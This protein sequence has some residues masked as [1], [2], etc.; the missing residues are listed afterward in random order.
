MVNLKNVEK[1]YDFYE[2]KSDIE[3]YGIPVFEYRNNNIGF[4]VRPT[5]VNYKESVISF[6][7]VRNGKKDNDIYQYEC[8]EISKDL[9]LV[10]VEENQY[11]PHLECV[12]TICLYDE[13][14]SFIGLLYFL[15]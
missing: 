2:L 9:R 3:N 7:I 10:E 6:W 1:A 14:D 11:H 15:R 5:E 13:S 8:L 4:K 12:K